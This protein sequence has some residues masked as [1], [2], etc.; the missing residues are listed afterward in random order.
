MPDV[1]VR[2]GIPYHQ[3]QG[4]FLVQPTGILGRPPSLQ[5][6]ASV[7]ILGIHG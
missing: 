7:V 1:M 3:E 4:P 5:W 6:Q 2:F